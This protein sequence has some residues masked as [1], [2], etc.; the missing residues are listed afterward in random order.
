MNLHQTYQMNTNNSMP[1]LTTV[2]KDYNQASILGNWSPKQN[3]KP[4]LNWPHNTAEV[5]IIKTCAYIW[6][7]WPTS[8]DISC[9]S[10]QVHIVMHIQLVY[11]KYGVSMYKHKLNFIAWLGT[12]D[13]F[14]KRAHVKALASWF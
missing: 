5:T 10:K 11:T 1:T 7:S 2:I 14:C 3:Y 4:E 6:T 9:D 8:K 13:V 12:M